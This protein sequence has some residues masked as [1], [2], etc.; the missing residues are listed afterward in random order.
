MSNPTLVNCPEDVWVKV[1]SNIRKVSIVPSIRS[2]FYRYTWRNTGDP[3]PINN[4]DALVVPIEGVTLTIFPEIDVY[5]ISTKLDGVVRV[6]I[7]NIPSVNSDDNTLNVRV[8]AP[9]QFNVARDLIRE[10]GVS[11]TLTVQANPG[12]RL[13]SIEPGEYAN[14]NV[15]DLTFLRDTIIEENIYR[16]IVD[17]PG[18]PVIALD[19]SIDGLYPIGSTLLT[20][21]RDVSTLIASPASPVSYSIGP[22][23]N[24]VWDIILTTMLVEDNLPMDISKFGGIPGGLLNGFCS[25]LSIAGQKI[26]AANFK[27]N[28]DLWMD[29]ANTI[30][31]NIAPGANSVMLGRWDLKEI[32]SPVRLNGAT[33]DSFSNVIQDDLTSLTQGYARSHGFISAFIL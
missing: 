23:I 12:D 25:E 26:T 15:G 2:P 27:N 5:V 30:F 8:V 13:I 4:N 28:G 20:V 1:A 9:F 33:V 29:N 31:P 10:L 16:R 14:F 32:K 6:A 7:S 21:E 18:S 3:P 24:Q 11:S 17:K 22:P 19:C